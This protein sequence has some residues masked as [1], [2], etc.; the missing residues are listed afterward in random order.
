MYAENDVIFHWKT[1]KLRTRNKINKPLTTKG[2][3]TVES[4]KALKI[5]Q[6]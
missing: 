2:F 1:C 3:L 5:D 6:T 4:L